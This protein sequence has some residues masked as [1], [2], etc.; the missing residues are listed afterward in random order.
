MSVRL[1]YGLRRYVWVLTFGALAVVGFAAWGARVTG[2]TYVFPFGR[3]PP[4]EA[5]TV[6]FAIAGLV[7][8]YIGFLS[9]LRYVR[10]PVVVLG[11]GSITVPVGEFGLRAVTLRRGD[12]VSIDER[13]APGGWRTLRVQHRGGILFVGSNQ[14][15]SDQDFVRV[16]EHIR[17]LLPA[18]LPDAS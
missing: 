10:K 1:R 5:R 2:P 3:L 18:P 14:L 9:Y 12:V 11:S 15:A 13:R 17:A 8:M 16:H 7:A 4:D 6:L